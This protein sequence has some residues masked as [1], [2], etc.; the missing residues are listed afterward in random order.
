MSNSGVQNSRYQSTPFFWIVFLPSLIWAGFALWQ[1][2]S[3]VEQGIQ[4]WHGILLLLGRVGAL[5]GILLLLKRADLAAKVFLA[6]TILFFSHRI[7]LIGFIKYPDSIEPKFSYYLFVP[8][9]WCASLVVFARVLSLK[10]RVIPPE[11]K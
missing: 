5:A 9:L 2:S 4:S 6:V 8:V 1:A 10:S 3:F 7:W 11:L